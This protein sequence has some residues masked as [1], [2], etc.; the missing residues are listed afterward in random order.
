MG[1]RFSGVTALIN[2]FPNDEDIVVASIEYRLAPESPAPAGAYDCY[3]GLVYL[4][5]HAAELDIDPTKIIIIGTSGGAGIAAAAV[6]LA[7]E[8]QRS[9]VCAQILNIPMLDDRIHFVSAGQFRS[10]TLWDGRANE[11]AWTMILDSDKE[12]VDEIRCPGRATNLSGLPSTFIDVGECEVFR[13]SAV[14]FASQIW[15]DGGSAELHVWPG[16]YHAAMY[17][18]PSVPV[19][20]AQDAALKNF[21]RRT[22]K[23]SVDI[24]VARCQEP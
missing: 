15:K 8:R 11:Q 6:L 19:S 18:E 22:L 20:Q 7:R 23:K 3:A 13:D 21:I 16:V 17:F 10:N 24:Y 9:L 14:A 12:C 2:F 5:D 1:N 4:V